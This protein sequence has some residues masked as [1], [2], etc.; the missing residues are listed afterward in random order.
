MIISLSRRVAMPQFHG[1][2]ISRRRPTGSGSKRSIHA[3]AHPGSVTSLA[4][5]RPAIDARASR[6]RDRAPN[7]REPRAAQPLE[8]RLE[9]Q[10]RVAMRA[11]M[12]S[13][14]R[15]SQRSLGDKHRGRIV[16]H[17]GRRLENDLHVF[18]AA[19][20][21]DYGSWSSAIKHKGRRA[22]LTSRG[23]LQKDACGEAAC[24]GFARRDAWRV[25]SIFD[26]GGRAGLLAARAMLL[27]ADDRASGSQRSLS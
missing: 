6:R 14:D 8:I 13:T 18:A 27:D 9:F 19:W 26:E 12:V 1:G 15:A 23:S 7:R 11:A 4:Q 16:D 21:S 2:T 5:R 10:R 17:R 25:K 24:A 20:C 22:S 3:V